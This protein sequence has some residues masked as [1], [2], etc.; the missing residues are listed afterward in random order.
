MKNIKNF[1]I[2]FII[3]IIIRRN[4]DECTKLSDKQQGHTKQLK[5]YDIFFRIS[6]QQNDH[7]DINMEVYPI[8]FLLNFIKM[9]WIHFF[10]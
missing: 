3:I 7:F 9:V 1:I 10:R 4:T 5:N 8:L 6:L 2:L